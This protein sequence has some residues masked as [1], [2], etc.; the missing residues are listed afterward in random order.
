ML[1]KT[2]FHKSFGKGT[3]TSQETAANKNTPKGPDE[4]QPQ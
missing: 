1:N 2:V 4:N 3:I